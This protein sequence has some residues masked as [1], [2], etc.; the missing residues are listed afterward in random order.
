MIMKDE[1]DDDDDDD[2]CQDLRRTCS[3][4]GSKRCSPN[5]D[6]PGQ[7]ETIFVLPTK[8]SFNNNV[9]DRLMMVLLMIRMVLMMLLVLMM[10]M[11]VSMMFDRP[12]SLPL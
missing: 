3:Q 11:N 1:E 8:T 10:N 5:H 4:R 2:T 7:A 12:P 6:L 9:E